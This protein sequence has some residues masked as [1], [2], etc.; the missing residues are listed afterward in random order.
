VSSNFG[1]SVQ[2]SV[3]RAAGTGL[4][5]IRQILNVTDS[6]IVTTSNGATGIYV[7]TQAG[8]QTTMNADGVTLVER[9]SNSSAVFV[10]NSADAQIASAN[11]VDTVIRGFSSSML[12]IDGHGAGAANI[13]TSYSDYDPT[14]NADLGTTGSITQTNRTNL[15]DARFVDAANDDY[16]LRHDSPLI[17]IGEPVDP[18][19]TVDLGGG[20]RLVDGDQTGGARRDIGA[21]EYQARAPSAAISGPSTGSTTEQLSFSGAGSFDPDPGDT[22]TYAWTLDGAPAGTGATLNATVATAGAH[23]IGLTVSDPVGRSAS[24]TASIT[25]AAPPGAGEGGTPPPPPPPPAD[26]VRP[27]ISNLTA[28]PARVRRGLRVTFRFTL[29]EVAAVRVEIQRARPGRRQGGRCRK[30]SQRNRSGQPCKRFVRV[31]L[32]QPAGTVGANSVRLA[33]RVGGRAMPAGA[34]RAVVKATDAAGNRAV[35]RRVSFTIRRR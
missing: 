21:F 15:G 31:A 13:T 26:I 14:N 19:T 18:T 9:G 16:R 25:I 24:T 11:L 29:S 1:G 20:L 22:L 32:L 10:S 23:T 12:T 34:Y 35:V 28:S 3:L 7:D 6:L 30:P 2:R 17:D 4:A 5:H 27:V 8:T 33:T